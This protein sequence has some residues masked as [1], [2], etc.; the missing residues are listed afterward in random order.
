MKA[1]AVEWEP[2]RWRVVATAMKLKSGAQMGKVGAREVE[3]V[4][5]AVEKRAKET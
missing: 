2:R 3:V 4:R 1:R 5:G